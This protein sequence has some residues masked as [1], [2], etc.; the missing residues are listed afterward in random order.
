MQ[1]LDLACPGGAPA[2]LGNSRP[3]ETIIQSSAADST[4]PSEGDRGGDKA[5][6]PQQQ[7]Q[8]QQLL[9]SYNVVLS[10]RL[11]LVVPRRAETCGPLAV[12]SLG[13]AGTLLVRSE[14]DAEFARQRG[15][16]GVLA[17]V[18]LPW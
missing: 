1:L 9:P 7:Q 18:G 11:M 14:G 2:P 17:A 3:A 6:P 5:V 4:A 16:A 15:P 13:F 10:R 8:Q 12:N